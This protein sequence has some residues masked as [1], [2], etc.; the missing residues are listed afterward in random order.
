MRGLRASAS[1]VRVLAP[2]TRRKIINGSQTIVDV[3]SM[4]KYLRLSWLKRIFGDNS[5]A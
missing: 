5:G 3:K 2:L 4:I 1:R